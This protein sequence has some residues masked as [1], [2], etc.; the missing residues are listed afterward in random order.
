MSK[1][2]SWQVDGG[3]IRVAEDCISLP[4]SESVTSN[5]EGQSA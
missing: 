3:K 5:D 1:L 2:G 4:K